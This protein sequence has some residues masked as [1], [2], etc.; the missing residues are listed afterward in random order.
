[1]LEPNLPS[2]SEPI[3]PESSAAL[4]VVP[5][6]TILRRLA[7]G[8]SATVYLAEQE[9]ADFR[10]EVALKVIDR[11]VDAES[12]RRVRDEERILARLEHPGIARLYDTGMTPFGQR[13][14]AMELV[15]GESILEHCRRSNLSVRQR[16][17]S[18]LGGARG[19]ELRP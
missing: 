1:M 12:S 5:G 16:T 7:R 13:Y 19:G 3:S 10:R 2:S 8:G 18:L 17:R 11:V 15:D 6:F 14:L 9:R 4:P